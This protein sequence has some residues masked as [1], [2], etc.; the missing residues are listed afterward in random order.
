MQTQTAFTA[1]DLAT[2]M[3]VTEGDV[4]AF[5][6]C[7]SVWTAKGYGLEAAIERHLRQ[8]EKL[9]ENASNPALRAVA[10]S[11]FFPA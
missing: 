4:V 9:A 11:A 10:V 6:A 2:E 5:I 7:L 1:K 8:M 3:G